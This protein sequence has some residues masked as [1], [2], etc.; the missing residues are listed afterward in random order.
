MREMMRMIGENPLA[1]VG[2]AFAVLLVLYF[3]LRTL[4]KIALVLLIIGVAVGG[5]FYFQYPEQ[6][7]A[8]LGEAVEKTLS[9]TGR[10][11]EKGKEALDKGRAVIGKGK[12]YVEKGKEIID[13]GKN[14]LDQGIDKGKKVIERGKSAA[15]DMGRIIG[16]EKGKASP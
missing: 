12:D 5:Y 7:P 10:T 14:A 6:R 11:L 4:V 2:V 3:F 8:S 13:Q 1:A 9:E 15:D 16:G